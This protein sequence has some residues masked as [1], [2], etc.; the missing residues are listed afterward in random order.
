MLVYLVFSI[1]DDGLRI[2]GVFEDLVEAF[3][4]ARKT[5]GEVMPLI[6]NREYEGGDVND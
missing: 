3:K 2:L 4:V 5:D 6:M 1:V